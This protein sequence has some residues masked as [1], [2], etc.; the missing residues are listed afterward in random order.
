MRLSSFD[1]MEMYEYIISPLVHEVVMNTIL[2]ELVLLVDSAP[3]R[4]RKGIIKMKITS[5]MQANR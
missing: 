2:Q 3:Y 1:N 5:K 4:K